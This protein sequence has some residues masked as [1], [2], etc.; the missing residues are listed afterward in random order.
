MIKSEKEWF[1]KAGKHW[2]Q[3]IDSGKMEF[4]RTVLITQHSYDRMPVVQQ[5]GASLIMY[6]GGLNDRKLTYNGL[7]PHDT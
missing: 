6:K 7:C 2:L 5:P 3:L 1:Q 4:K